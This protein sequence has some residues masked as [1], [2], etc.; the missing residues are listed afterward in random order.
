MSVY[1]ADE[2]L[3]LFIISIKQKKSLIKKKRTSGLKLRLYSKRYRWF[4]FLIFF[5]PAEI[6][7]FFRVFP[8]GLKQNFNRDIYT[9]T[10]VSWDS[11]WGLSKSFVFLS[12]TARN[13]SYTA[14]RRYFWLSRAGT[15]ICIVKMSL[16]KPSLEFAVN[17]YKMNLPLL[18]GRIKNALRKV[19]CYIETDLELKARIGF[20]LIGHNDVTIWHQIFWMQF[21][22]VNYSYV[23]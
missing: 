10:V 3:F 2:W 11:L 22:F 23:L 4:F 21:G 9:W 19:K 16:E 14:T 6:I 18:S 8:A 5:A 17:L 1:I 7:F 12:P 20:I 13:G 15:Y